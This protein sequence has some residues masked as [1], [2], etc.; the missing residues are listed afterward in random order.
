VEAELTGILSNISPKTIAIIAAEEDIRL[1]LSQ[2][3]EKDRHPK[4]M[5]NDFKNQIVERL[6]EVSQ[7]L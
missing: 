7:G 1:Y 6:V 3:L 2:Q 4:A 5:N